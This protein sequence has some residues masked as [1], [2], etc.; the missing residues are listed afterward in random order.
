MPR[1]ATNGHGPKRAVLYARVSTQEQADK[2]Y[3]LAQQMEALRAYATRE[4]FE[5]LEEVSD[6]GYSGAYLDRPGL[7]QVRGLVEGTPGGVSVVLAQDR[8]RIAREPAYLYLLREEF[9]RH[10]CA[11]RALNDRGDDSPEG[12][13]TDG[14]LDQL[15]KFER[16]KTAERTRR[17]SRRKAAEGKVLGAALKPRYG[18]RYAR[19]TNGTPVGYVVDEAEMAVV[20]RMMREFADGAS[21]NGV[22]GGLTGD[23]I[24]AP[25]GGEVWSR[26]TV[27]NA[28]K[29]DAYKPHTREELEA[30]A[31]EGRM[32]PDVLALLDP[33]RPYGVAWFGR[34]RKVGR[35]E[36]RAAPEESWIA[37]PVDLSGSNLDRETVEMARRNVASNR[38]L[39]KVGDRS[40]ELSG[41]LLR[42]GDCGRSMLAF[43][44]RYPDRPNKPNFYYRCDAR[45]RVGR[46]CPNRRSHRAADI[47]ARAWEIVAHAH[48]DP[49][50]DFMRQ[51]EAA[52]EARKLE[53]AAG[54]PERQR[55]L[56]EELQTLEAERK[57]Y[58][59]QNARGVLSDAELDATLADVGERAGKLREE[60]GRV[61]NAARDLE[62]LEDAYAA[63]MGALKSGRVTVE[64]EETPESRRT[65][66]KRAGV[67][68][69]LDEEGTVRA[70]FALQGGRTA[71]STVTSP[72]WRRRGSG[73][74]TTSK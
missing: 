6:P 52:Y 40:W 51:F 10:G 4:G 62:I 33:S 29:D 45:S 28:A 63:A 37:V 46:P 1:G 58:L 72:T 60:Q 69:T 44:R 13:L 26:F 59:R 68:F 24:P 36:R 12:Q 73:S 41:G 39:S 70:E 19:D 55:A 56:V 11:L 31:A 66:Y 65:W 42:C 9:L 57:G 53:L 18:F 71:S 21:V 25:S 23:G 5:V 32:R 54:S 38:K 20:R 43:S 27:R 22:A 3:S 67:A 47:E 64:A 2:G 48:R 7:D 14:I 8:D 16:A 74:R 34:T 17:R 30:L 49:H 15:A 35:Y 50:G 61:G